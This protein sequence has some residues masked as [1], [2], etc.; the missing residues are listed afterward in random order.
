MT[1]WIFVLLLLQD[2][3]VKLVLKS[4]TVLECTTYSQVGE[5]VVFEVVPG[6]Q[7][8]S[9]ITAQQK[10]KIPVAKVDW[11]RTRSH[12]PQKSKTP[13]SDSPGKD[14]IR[15]IEAQDC[16]AVRPTQSP[17]QP[18]VETQTHHPHVASS[19]PD[20]KTPVPSSRSQQAT[21]PR[22]SSAGPQAVSSKTQRIQ[23]DD[24]VELPGSDRRSPAP[25]PKTTVTPQKPPSTANSP[26]AEMKHPEN[27]RR[28]QA[29]DAL[30]SEAVSGKEN[31]VVAEASPTK[32]PL[33][34][35]NAR[36]PE[37]LERGVEGLAD[38][39]LSLTGTTETRTVQPH[40]IPFEI[41]TGDD[42]IVI[43]SLVI[44]AHEGQHMQMLMEGRQ[45]G[46]ALKTVYFSLE[47]IHDQSLIARGTEYLDAEPGRVFFKEFWIQLDR[48]PEDAHAELRFFCE[49]LRQR[50]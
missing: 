31:S 18:S 22:P 33:A 41:E 45:L 49:P 13:R 25:Q 9:L 1:H 21:V 36:A 7:H 39:S 6:F 8:P 19:I 27:T 11:E 16:G 43:T 26:D 28:D 38:L 32:A 14:A 34:E 23:S 44:V 30:G 37:L 50:P 3:P 5:W 10:Y 12:A 17:T 40:S 24:A 35:P 2:E 48:L 46:Q 4:G 20:T 15:P 47:L 29:W 42:L